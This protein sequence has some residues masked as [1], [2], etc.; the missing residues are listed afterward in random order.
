MSPRANCLEQ[1][2]A[3]LRTQRQSKSVKPKGGS[4]KR[5]RTQCRSGLPR[6]KRSNQTHASTT[7]PD[8]KLYR[9]GA[10]KEA[11]LCFMGHR[12]M[13]TATAYWSTRA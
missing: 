6:P 11:N 12:L 5:R 9:K 2:F 10:G 4:G 1:I 7:D 3:S 13:E 8:A